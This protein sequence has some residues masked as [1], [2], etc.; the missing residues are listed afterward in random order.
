M[1][2][3]ILGIFVLIAIVAGLVW[4]F[5][6]IGTYMSVNDELE[7]DDFVVEPLYKQ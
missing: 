5:E 2:E 3:M 6:Q 1:L 4:V 7:F